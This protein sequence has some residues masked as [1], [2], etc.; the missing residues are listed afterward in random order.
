MI[1]VDLKRGVFLDPGTP[2]RIGQR[3]DKVVLLQGA[4][5]VQIDTPTAVRTG[6]QL[7]KLSDQVLAGE[8]IALRIDGE[9]L[10]LL[11]EVARQIGGALIR[12][13]DRADDFQRAVH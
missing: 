8:F 3:Y 2:V 13:A 9:E 12:K 5:G 10:H 1:V 11:P 4:K 6:F 7:V